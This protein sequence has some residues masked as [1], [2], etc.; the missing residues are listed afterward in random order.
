MGVERDCQFLVE[1]SFVLTPELA[2]VRG[3]DNSSCVYDFWASTEDTTVC[4]C[5]HLTTFSIKLE[6]FKA[7]SQ[8]YHYRGF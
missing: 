8:S 2:K 3:W 6:D 4:N 5:T 1:N 7:S